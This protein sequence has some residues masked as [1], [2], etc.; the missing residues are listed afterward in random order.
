MSFS[1]LDY[2]YQHLPARVRRDDADL[3][4]KRFLRFFGETLDSWDLLF[5]FFFQQINPETASE[6]FINFWLWALFG[7]SWFPKWFTLARKRQLYADFAQHLARRGTNLG[8]EGFLKAFSIFSRVYNR[9]QYWGDFVWGEGDYTI[10]DALG[11]AVQVSHLADEVNKDVQGNAWG[12]FAW[13]EGYFRDTEATLTRKEIE[14]LLRFE[15]PNGQRMMVGYQVRRNVA[16]VQAWES[17]E[18]ILNEEIVP[19]ENSGAITGEN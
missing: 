2:L 10:T 4:L 9:P 14:D 15:W 19:D 12:E 16:G 11:I 6:P 7:W 8:I 17:D 5:E 18:P 3:F 13:G 1:N